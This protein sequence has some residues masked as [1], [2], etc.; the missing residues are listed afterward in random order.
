MNLQTI[1][2]F[3]RNLTIGQ[4]IGDGLA[5]VLI[6]TTFIEI[7]PIKWDPLTSIL[8]WLGNRINKTV[9]KDV[10]GLTKTV[11]EQAQKVDDLDKKID[12]N[13]ID[14]IRW[15]ILNFSNSCRHDQLHTKDEFEH[16]INLHE[17]YIEILDSRHM[18]NG[19]ITLE[20]EYIVEIYKKRLE[21]NDFL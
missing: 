1:I 18:T 11:Q 12:M 10:E 2:E 3:F 13:E 6:F 14:H 8:S 16:I 9:L 7:S 20:Y 15:E 19:L 5:L 21:K 17:K 4:I